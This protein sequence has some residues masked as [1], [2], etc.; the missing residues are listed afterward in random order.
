MY[1]FETVN[2]YLAQYFGSFFGRNMY[3]KFSIDLQNLR[4]GLLLKYSLLSSNRY[5]MCVYNR[6]EISIGV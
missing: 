1:L 3:V 4:H 6:R 2:N 5:S